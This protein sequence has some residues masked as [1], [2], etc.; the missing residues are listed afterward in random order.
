MNRFFLL[1]VVLLG[2]TLESSFASEGAS[3]CTER[4]ASIDSIDSGVS[5]VEVER[6]RRMSNSE[7]RIARNAIFAQYGRVF[8][9]LDL[10]EY[11]DAQGWYTP[12]PNYT[13]DALSD[14]ERDLVKVIRM[15]EQSR[16]ML[17]HSFEDLNGD[18]E[19]DFSYLLLLDNQYCLLVNDQ[20]K[21]LPDYWADEKEAYF[22]GMTSEIWNIDVSNSRQ[23]VVLSQRYSGW[24][25]P[26]MNNWIIGYNG[27]SLSVLEL[28]AGDY[29][30]GGVSINQN[31]QIT[32]RVSFCPDHTQVF[33]VHDGRLVLLNEELIP[34]PYPCPACISGD[35]M[36][37]MADGMTR[38]MSELRVGMKVR[39]YHL[40][41]SAW[42]EA[43][44]ES[45]VQVRHNHL[46][47]YEFNGHSVVAT[48]D[49]PFFAP[50]KGWV[51]LQPEKTKRNYRDY[52]GVQHLEEGDAILSES[53]QLQDL[54]STSAAEGGETYSI[55]TLN[56][57]HGFLAN[58]IL[59]GTAQV[60]RDCALD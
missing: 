56:W 60:K 16:E 2:F 50:S 14:E 53:G 17:W 23:E 55:E 58:G 25:D 15:W 46:V 28:G 51:S 13:V 24:E 30:S 9:S 38:R 21:V 49:H 59:V 42:R 20:V 32:L 27:H 6:L 47:R 18:G 11:F 45:L 26:G 1:V 37:T 43:E 44:V 29:N 52:D 39:G 12:N 31:G 3:D 10:Q 8:K 5:L 54:M 41:E 19:M 22:R 35:A 40:V 57:G 34:S 7:R 36:I 4:L 33:A 48:D